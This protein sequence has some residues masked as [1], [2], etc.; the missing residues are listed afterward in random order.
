MWSNFDRNGSATWV[1]DSSTRSSSLRLASLSLN[2]RVTFKCPIHAHFVIP[3]EVDYL[4]YNGIRNKSL[5]HWAHGFVYVSVLFIWIYWSGLEGGRF[6]AGMQSIL[7]IL[8]FWLARTK[9]CP[10][11]N[12]PKWT[13]LNWV[14]RKSGAKH[15]EI[16]R[17]ALF[18]AED[19]GFRASH[20]K[21]HGSWFG[22]P[23]TIVLCQFNWIVLELHAKPPSGRCLSQWRSRVSVRRIWRVEIAPK[24]F[25]RWGV[26]SLGFF[27]PNGDYAMS[28]K[29]KG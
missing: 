23:T 19:A 8:G 3:Y 7:R 21:Y 11:K 18:S 13:E 22:H 9:I 25:F 2:K 1:I 14:L 16:T 28:Q 15:H 4:M 5:G 27:L 26:A 20:W 6:P 17:A 24:C 12:E 10:V 29:L